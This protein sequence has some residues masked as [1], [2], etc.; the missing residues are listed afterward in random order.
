MVT[1][2]HRNKKKAKKTQKLRKIRRATPF[3]YETE[4]KNNMSHIF[5][6]DPDRHEERLY[7]WNDK[8]GHEELKTLIKNTLFD[9]GQQDN[10]GVVERFAK[11]Y[12]MSNTRSEFGDKIMMQPRS[13]KS[14]W[15]NNPERYERMIWL[16]DTLFWPDGM[17]KYNDDEIKVSAIISAVKERGYNIAPDDAIELAEMYSANAEEDRRQRVFETL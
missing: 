5:N 16:D 10:Y 8:I 14:V 9:E 3:V 17:K 2:F 11:A 4:Y 1:Q 7:T 6:M 13:I 12:E 15:L